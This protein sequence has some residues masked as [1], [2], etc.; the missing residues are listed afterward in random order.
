M[1]V[2]AIGQATIEL[3]YGLKVYTLSEQNMEDKLIH[4]G[5]SRFMSQE[6]ITLPDGYQQIEEQAHENGHSLVYVA[7]DHTLGGAIELVPTIRPEAQQIIDDLHERNIKVMIISG[8]HEKP[9]K[10]LA[11][12]LN[13]D[14]YFAE[15]LPQNKAALVEQLQNEGRSVCFV[16]DGINDAIALKQATVS[17][18]LSGASSAATDT[19]SIV[20]MDTSLKQIT[21][22]LELA[23]ELDK[24]LTS[25]TALTVVPGILCAGGVFFL[26]LGVVS[27]LILFNISLVA[28]LSN[29]MRPLIKHQR[30]NSH[31]KPRLSTI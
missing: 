14:Q 29:A 25:S 4:V 11:Q 31:H 26:H 1:D 23:S 20:L 21:S 8:D 7:I 12:A 22:L 2:P 5:S 28:S 18:S 19:A 24:S 13:I 17:I 3:G 30:E 9:T 15:V 10:K 6:D 16:G 27:A